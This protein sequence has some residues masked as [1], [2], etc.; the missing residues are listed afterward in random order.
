MK[1]LISIF[2]LVF[3]TFACAQ[4]S[5]WMASLDD[6][7]PAWRVSIPGTHDSGTAGVRFP[8]RHYART[9]AMTL[10]EQW[11]AGIRFFDLRPKPDGQALGIY[12]GPA[13][14]HITF[15]ESL[16]VLTAKL[17]QNPTE[18]CIVMTNLAG[19]GQKAMEMV[20]REIHNTVPEQ[21]TAS[22]TSD[23]KVKDLRG[24]ILFIHRSGKAA[25]AFR[26][27]D[28]L[29]ASDSNEHMPL[30]W[31][32]Y[33]CG[34]GDYLEYKWY[35]L[36]NMLDFFETVS[37]DAWCI[38]HASGYTGRGI[39]TDIRRNANV[40][41]PRL[42]ERLLR[43]PVPTGIIPMD[44]PSQELIDAIISCNRDS[45]CCALERSS[46]CTSVFIPKGTGS[47]TFSRFMRNAFPDSCRQ[48]C[49]LFRYVHFFEGL[50][51][52]HMNMN[53]TSAVT[54]YVTTCQTTGTEGGMADMFAS[55]ASMNTKAD[56]RQRIT[57]ISSHHG[58]IPASRRRREAT[59]SDRNSTTSRK[60]PNSIASTWET[61][62]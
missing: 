54:E 9:Q 18:F 24:K 29:Y 25:G 32:D 59:A 2:L 40:T 6:T 56:V 23:L 33:F 7:M 38:N 34:N 1:R 28:N 12:H 46:Y 45:P 22:F 20:D 36:E 62:S 31:Q 51:N 44:F 47:S 11:E 60:L 5:G 13:D 17:Q 61:I 41:N 49:S 4:K 50:Q 3:C 16:Q 37:Y 30:C 42:L 58:L 35:L 48:F 19:G 8:A 55:P 26:R 53:P 15:I 52:R 14:C 10:A 43:H 27:G 39:S 21:M 57:G